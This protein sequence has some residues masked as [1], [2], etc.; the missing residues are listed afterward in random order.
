MIVNHHYRF[1]FIKTRKTAGTSIE[2]ALSAFCG[3][4]DIITPIHPADEA[5]RCQLGY[6]RPQNFFIP[7]RGYTKGD[8]LRYLARAERKQFFNH[9]SAAF[10]ARNLS[11]RIWQD[12]FKFCFERDPFDKAV[13]RYFW[14]TNQPRPPISEFLHQAPKAL[15][16]N[17]DLYTI[18]DHICVD[19]LGRFETLAD[20]LRVIEARLG[21]PQ[22]LQLPRAKAGYRQDRRHYSG[23]LGSDARAR[24]ET[25][26]A[27]EIAVLGYRWR[28][29]G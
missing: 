26:C 3:A 24:I 1:I 2:I 21:L 15:L 18:N 27:K 20:D 19:F 7:R 4:D 25:V 22:A 10:I 23:M 9:S 14:S 29:E 8:W 6:R 11:E 17:W 5:I 28:D 13:S 16:S 12:Y